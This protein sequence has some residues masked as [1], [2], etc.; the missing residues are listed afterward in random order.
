MRLAVPGATG[1][2][3]RLV[4]NWLLAF[5]P[6]VVQAVHAINRRVVD[7]GILANDPR[8]VS[9]VVDMTSGDA[10]AS[11]CGAI[12][13][14]VDAVIA[15]MGIGTGN[16]SLEA[17]RHVEVELPSAFARTLEA[18]GLDALHQFRV[19]AGGQDDVPVGG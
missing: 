12:L 15:T 7:E 19:V 6:D 18:P 16:G 1:N 4:V 11:G 14:D 5:D 9:H 17:F 8:L 3:G 13:E 10:L 2:V